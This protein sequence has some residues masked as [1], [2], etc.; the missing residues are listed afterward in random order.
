MRIVIRA[1]DNGKFIEIPISIKV[2]RAVYDFGYITDSVWKDV[3]LNKIEKEISFFHDK[4]EW[5]IH[6]IIDG[7]KTFHQ[8]QPIHHVS[9]TGK[10][11]RIIRQDGFVSSKEKG[12]IVKRP[13]WILSKERGYIVKK[14]KWKRIKR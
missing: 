12:L 10:R 9:I 2:W 7:G 6:D 13:K 5:L 1:E 3:K 11:A 14:P 8:E 4:I